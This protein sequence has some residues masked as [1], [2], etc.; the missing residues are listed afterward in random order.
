VPGCYKNKKE[1]RTL[2]KIISIVGARPQFIKCAAL[3][4]VIRINYNEIILHSGQ[5][6]DS[7][8]S[9]VF[10]DELEIPKPKYN[11]GIGSGTH[12]YQTGQ[13]LIGIEQI[14]LEEKPDLV[15]VFGDTN[16]TLAGALA[17]RKLR[18]FLAHVEAG[19][20]LGSYEHPEEINR[21]LSD[22]CSDINFCPN[23]IS[24]TNLVK[25]NLTNG[26]YLT[27]DV[28]VDILLQQK[29]YSE[30]STILENIGTKSK[31]YIV[32]TIHR[33]D[34][35][36]NPEK[37]INIVEAL[38]QITDTIIFPIHPRTEKAL[39]QLRLEDKLRGNKNVNV[40]KPVGYLDMIKL[41][42]HAKC[43][44]T[45]SGGIQKEAYILKVPC[46]TLLNKTPWDETREDGWNVTVGTSVEQI[47]KMARE[48]EPTG[49]QSEDFGGGNAC[50]NIEN[51]INSILK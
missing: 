43:I 44:I 50:H 37:L 47:V 29:K 17:A 7:T 3:S 26:V 11:L 40:I 12:G 6:Y 46:I 31:H 20:R 48:F 35:T 32:V 4:R 28:M 42:N 2:K 18:M 34:N 21:R 30:K 15:I 33:S 23:K 45:D 14:L 5:H 9:E 10:F 25:E 16:T 51:I 24:V 41:M 8:L 1:V 36:D 49:P 22:H 38:C 19:L 39:K 13:M 27:G